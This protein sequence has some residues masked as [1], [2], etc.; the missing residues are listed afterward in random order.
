LKWIEYEVDLT[1]VTNLGNNALA[2]SQAAVA[3]AQAAASTASAANVTANAASVTASNASA[4]AS[5]ADAKAVAADTVADGAVVTANT[6]LS[7]AQAAGA[8]KAV[9]DALIA[10]TSGGQGIRTKPDVSGV[11]WY[12]RRNMYACVTETRLYGTDNDNNA[13]GKNTRKLNT[14]AHDSGSLVSVDPATGIVTFATAGNYYVK[15]YACFFNNGDTRQ[16]QLLVVAAATDTLWL[17]GNS[18]HIAGCTITSKS[19]VSGILTATANMT[20]RL[21][22]YISNVST[23]GL[24]KAVS[25]V[26][27]PL[28]TTA[29]VYAQLEIWY[30]G[31]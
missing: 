26:P 14:E 13:A 19:E 3:T 11:E 15:G 6:A 1:T 31:A 22:H 12:S 25:Q 21:D 17:I 2:T 9:N 5:A 24:G 16:H 27:N 7:T 29:E 4:A 8:K 18:M 23:T 28:L 10:S 20:F 30:L